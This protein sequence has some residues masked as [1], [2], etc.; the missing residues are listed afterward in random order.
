MK[1]AEHPFIDIELFSNKAFLR[2][3]TVGFIINVALCAN[4]LLLPLLLGREHGLF[5]LLSELYYLLH[6]SLVL[7]LVLLLER[8]SLRLKCEYDLCSVCHYDCWLLILGFIPNGSIVVIVLAII[9]TFMSYSAIQ[10]SLN[11]FIPKTL[12]A[13][14]VES[15]LAYII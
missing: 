6:H 10:V 13:A 9:L 4:L 8:L 15:V 11:T 3:I 5:H 12:H 2:L 14:K 7:C 1:K